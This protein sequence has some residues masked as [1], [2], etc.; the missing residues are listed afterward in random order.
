MLRPSFLLK[1]FRSNAPN[2]Y[3]WDIL[4]KGNLGPGPLIGN[5]LG[6][7]IEAVAQAGHE[8]GVHAWD[9]HAWQTRLDR[10]TADRIST[11][12]R[13]AGDELTR[14]TARPPA[15]SASPAWMCTEASLRAKAGLPYLYNSD[16]RGD[17]IF[18]PTV[19]DE[20]IP[21]PQVPSNLPVYDET[22]GRNGVTLQ[23][24]PDYLLSN[25]RAHSYNVLTA[26]AEV[27]GNVARDAFHGFLK[28]ASR[29][30]YRFCTLGEL[31]T[32]AKPD[33][34]PGRIARRPVPGR[35]GWL[36]VLAE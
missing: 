36:S 31:A 3:G 33:L 5:R 20:I 34:R 28:G 30:G 16:C 11:E 17:R 35:E 23:T 10:W 19:Q 27:E 1:M 26:H 18:L 14:I 32:T 25:L 6:P 12:L 22:V 15:C 13:R 9:H 29:Q 7:T 24:Y 21:Q 4:L 2:L 8:V